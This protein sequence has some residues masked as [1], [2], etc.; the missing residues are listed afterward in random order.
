MTYEKRQE[1]MA[2]YKRNAKE[3]DRINDTAGRIRWAYYWRELATDSERARAP[4]YL[5]GR[6]K[7]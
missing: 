1:I 7:P 3:A 2:S 5:I 6:I 4:G